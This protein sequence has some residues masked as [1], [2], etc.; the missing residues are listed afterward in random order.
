[1]GIWISEMI[2]QGL[3]VHYINEER[4]YNVGCKDGFIVAHYQSPSEM[5][6]LWQNLHEKGAANCCEDR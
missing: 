6:C 2:E 1:M 3:Q 5:L 4:V